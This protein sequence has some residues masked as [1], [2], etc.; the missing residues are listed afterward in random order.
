MRVRADFDFKDDEDGVDMISLKKGDIIEVIEKGEEGGWWRGRLNGKEGYFPISYC[1]V[2]KDGRESPSAHLNVNA[3]GLETSFSADTRPG[4]L[5]RD[6]KTSLLKSNGGGPPA[7]PEYNT[8]KI[9]ILKMKGKLK[10][11]VR[12]AETK[13]APSRKTGEKQALLKRRKSG[14]L[15]LDTTVKVPTQFFVWAHNMALI[16][17]AYCIILGF[18]ALIWGGLED[19][20]GLM[21]GI[22]GTYVVCLGVY[23]I[24]FEK[25]FGAER[26]PSAIPKRGFMYFILGFPCYFTY[27]TVLC[28]IIIYITAV[29]HCVSAFYEEEI[30]KPRKRKKAKAAPVNQDRRGSNAVIAVRDGIELVEPDPTCCQRLSA[31]ITFQQNSNK[32]GTK[33]F[34]L[35][36]LILNVFFF[37][38]AVVLWFALNS[39]LE[40][41]DQISA[42]G[43]FAKGFGWTLDFNCSIILIPVCRNLLSIIYDWSSSQSCLGRCLGVIVTFIPVDKNIAF[44]KLIAVVMSG[45]AAGHMFF[46]FINYALRPDQ[47]IRLFGIIPWYSGGL[48]VLCIFLIFSGAQLTV[49]RKQFEIF[50]YTHIFVFPLFFILILIHGKNVFTIELE[51]SGPFA[52][53]PDGRQPYSEGQYC[54][55]NCPHI[56]RFEWH[57]FTIS[58]A[59]YDKTVSFHIRKSVP[60]SWTD[61]L[62]TY[63]TALGPKTGSRIVL[64]RGA[65]GARKMGKIVGPDGLQ[66]LKIDGPHSAPTQHI[67]KYKQVMVV[68]AGIGVTPVASSCKSVVF[69]K[70]RTAVGEVFPH[71]AY[72]YW[73]CSHRDVDSFRWLVRLIK[74]CQ[75][76][77][78]HQ[79]SMAGAPADRRFEFHIYITSV[80]GAQPVEVRVA[81]EDD[82]AFWGRHVDKTGVEKKKGPFDE[83][84]LY[85]IMKCPPTDITQLGDIYVHKGRPN[86]KAEF[87]RVKQY[88]PRQTVG[89]AFCGNPFI[90]KDLRRYSVEFTDVTQQQMFRLHLENF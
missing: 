40:E 46:H 3:S 18:S 34:L 35:V 6:S 74:E 41:R 11:R 19:K 33:I 22:I 53:K 44:H 57:P 21:Y 8:S 71:N 85:S 68:G 13:G 14:F 90:A 12:I 63:L 39:E 47:T 43:P 48:I 49:R 86:W 70:W 79:R 81:P 80:R 52:M 72:F 82:E 83:A 60:G 64:H 15:A 27:P 78:T 69:H 28:G 29:V 54:F 59:P 25:V 58:S 45:C 9:K 31:W 37:A 50:W 88:H 89:I 67:S 38:Y 2:I 76:E 1:T 17:A 62:S 56:S 65:G 4:A 7:L 24:L 77:V 87:T 32:L 61:Q 84:K 51:K 5:R 75:D 42:V 10:K 30:K 26:L 23:I 66:L 20:W 73:V 16:S 36:Y 55:I